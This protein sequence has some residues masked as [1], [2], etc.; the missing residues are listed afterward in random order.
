MILFFNSITYYY[1]FEM[2]VSCN[3]SSAIAELD[4]L[5]RAY[6]SL[7]HFVTDGLL[8]DMDKLA[9]WGMKRREEVDRIVDENRLL[10]AENSELKENNKKL[11]STIHEFTQRDFELK[12]QKKKM[13]RDFQSYIKRVRIAL[14]IIDNDRI[15][16]LATREQ[17]CIKELNSATNN[18]SFA[19]V[20]RQSTNLADLDESQ[21]ASWIFGEGDRDISREVLNESNSLQVAGVGN[22]SRTRSGRTYSRCAAD[23]IQSSSVAQS[24]ESGSTQVC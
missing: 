17:E 16:G 11:L 21:E 10:Q 9:F 2:A 24:G 3:G 23:I 19:G 7:L 13:E 14:G 12:L 4:Y 15:S 6:N 8:P 22:T 1:I 18:F 5:Q 20:R